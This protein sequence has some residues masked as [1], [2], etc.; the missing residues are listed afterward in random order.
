MSSLL[1]QVST[2]LNR[3]FNILFVADPEWIKFVTG[4]NH[5]TSCIFTI[6]DLDKTQDFLF[7]FYLLTSD[8][9]STIQ[10][11]ATIVVGETLK[12]K[13]TEDDTTLF[14][15]EDQTDLKEILHLVVKRYND[16]YL[17]YHASLKSRCNTFPHASE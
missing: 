6:Q 2:Y 17:E 1:D 9:N 13:M 11:D 12:M 10:I 7:D 4:G 3:K 14:V 15:P 5:K 16:F 8:L